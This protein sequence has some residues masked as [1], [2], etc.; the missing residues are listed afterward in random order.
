MTKVQIPYESVNF[1]DE[2]RE[3][4]A[5]MDLREN[6]LRNINRVMRGSI[7]KKKHKR[8][9][10]EV[11]PGYIMRKVNARSKAEK[12]MDEKGFKRK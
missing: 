1:T 3:L 5:D 11:L 7:T 6:Q 4:L 12:M 10:E 9:S 2:E 8:M